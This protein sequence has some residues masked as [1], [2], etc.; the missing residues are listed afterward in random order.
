MI[1]VA[2]TAAAATTA[3]ATAAAAAAAAPT[4]H[5]FYRC[6]EQRSSHGENCLAR[7]GDGRSALLRLLLLLL[8]CSSRCVTSS[9]CTVL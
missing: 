5:F 1:C 8:L 7:C 2:T 3:T 9:D 6:T 4:M